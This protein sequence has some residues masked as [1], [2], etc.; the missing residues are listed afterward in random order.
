MKKNLL[1]YSGIFIITLSCILSCNNTYDGMIE[2]F[3]EEYF[4][5]GYNAK[6]D[7]S[8]TSDD[9][10]EDDMLMSIISTS[11]HSVLNLIAPDGGSGCSYEWKL[12]VP[13]YNSTTGIITEKDYVIGTDRF[14]FYSVPGKM[15][16]DKK[17]KLV[18]NVTDSSGRIYSDTATIYIE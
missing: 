18:L 8:V 12:I 7:Y 11:D 1:F 2:E 5:K 3:N 17:N 14:L 6:L 15:N 16:A 13:E 4:V 9:F 10:S